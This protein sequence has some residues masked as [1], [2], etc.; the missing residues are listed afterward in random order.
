[1]GKKTVFEEQWITML[2]VTHSMG[3]NCGEPVEHLLQCIRTHVEDDDGFE[4]AVTDFDIIQNLEDLE[5]TGA[6]GG[7]ADATR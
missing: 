4:D 6:A 1:M 7:S 5:D 2:Y 3:C